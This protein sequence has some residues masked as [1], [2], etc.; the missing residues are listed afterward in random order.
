MKVIIAGSRNI[1]NINYLYK[2]IQESGFEITE[3]VTGDCRGV[4]K[5]G[6]K[7]ANVHKLKI[8]GFPADW[9]KHGKK[10]GPL[11]NTVMANYAD[12]LIAIWNGTSTGTIDMIRKARQKGLEVYVYNV[13]GEEDDKK[14]KSDSRKKV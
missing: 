6:I 13:K 3:V 5:L 12:A 1:D 11:R 7:Y 10:A 4:D 2:A 9:D 14:E 8:T